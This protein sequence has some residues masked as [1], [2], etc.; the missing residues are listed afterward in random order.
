M[1]H[2][3]TTWYTF[4]HSTWPRVVRRTLHRLNRSF[5]TNVSLAL[6]KWRQY[7]TNVKMYDY[8]I[9][10]T[11][12]EIEI[13]KIKIVETTLLNARQKI[14][15]RYVLRWQSKQLHWGF[16]QWTTCNHQLM[17]NEQVLQQKTEKENERKQN[18]TKR[19]NHITSRFL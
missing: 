6:E 3:F 17:H 19:T 2:F 5:A 9:L 14:A 10:K 16:R 13:E 4:T 7:V 1:Q 15:R 12:K 18:H 11:K 8:Y